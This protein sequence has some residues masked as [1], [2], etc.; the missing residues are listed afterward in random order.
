MCA[1]VVAGMRAAYGK[2]MVIASKA[3]SMTKSRLLFNIQFTCIHQRVSVTHH[4]SKPPLSSRTAERPLGAMPIA[5]QVMVMDLT[6]R[7]SKGRG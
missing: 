6:S 3:N 7:K 4:E 5:G 2:D 1:R